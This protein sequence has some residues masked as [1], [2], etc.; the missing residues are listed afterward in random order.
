VVPVPGLPASRIV[1]GP[2]LSF[3][4]QSSDLRYLDTYGHGTHLAGIMVGDDPATGFK[5]IAPAAKLTSVKVGSATGAVDVSQVIAAIDW[6]VA[7]KNDD[8]ANPIKVLCLA[9]GTDANPNVNTDPL[10]FAVENAAN[11]AGILVVVA[12]G[13]QGNTMGRVNSPAMD[14][15]MLTVGSSSTRCTT[16]LADD[17]LSTFTSVDNSMLLDVVAPGESIVSL[18]NPGAYADVN[19]PSA[20]VGETLFR[21]T[22]SS[23]ATA[24]VSAA[25]ALM[26]EKYPSTKPH[27][28]REWL[29]LTATNVTGTNASRTEGSL[30]LAAALARPAPNYS[31][32]S[33]GSSGLGSLNAARGAT[34]ASDN[35]VRLS[36][37][38]DVLGSWSS[39]SWVNA[40]KAG[41]AWKGGVWMG[42]RMAG[43]GWTGSSWA[44]KTW[45]AASWSG[46][47]WNS[48]PW[49]DSSWSGRYW[50]GRYW[51]TTNW[52]GRYWSASTWKTKTWG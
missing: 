42:R 32:A 6:V 21:G 11:K 34:Y 17:T 9:Y 7:H 47:N 24:V 16:S 1:N 4:S 27:V 29:R 10:L 3:E 13:N 5:G 44:S 8:P 45:S 38:S 33:G 18:R 43:D 39:S 35:G 48:K 14:R 51:S 22:G 15:F 37:E 52:S 50:S 19:Y 23:Q 2:D 31:L 30:N 40:V 26:L 25:A 28:P 41:S 46:T 49:V 36:G 12:G 20:R